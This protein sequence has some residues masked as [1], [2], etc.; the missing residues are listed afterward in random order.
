[1]KKEYTVKN[2]ILEIFLIYIRKIRFI[3]LCIIFLGL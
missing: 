1:M 3:I 2:H